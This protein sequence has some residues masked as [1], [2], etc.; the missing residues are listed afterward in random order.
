MKISTVIIDDEPLARQRIANL[1]KTID[2]I[3]VVEECATGKKAIESINE[4]NPALIFL[5]IKLKD[6]TGFDVLQQIEKSARPVIIFVTA[7][8]Q[9][10]LKAFEY[11]ALDY[12][13]KPFKDE[14]FYESTNKAIEI[15]KQKQSSLLENNLQN[16]LD[17]VNNN[18]KKHDSNFKKTPGKTRQQDSFYK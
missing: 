6:M 12:L 2:D 18:T 13:Q 5:D 14:R 16:L 3:E 4:L 1:L 11:F 7:F 15:I 17:Y 8:D 9:F 10:A